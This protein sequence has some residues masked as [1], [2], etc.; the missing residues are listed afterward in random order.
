MKVPSRG[1]VIDVLVARDGAA[2]RLYFAPS[3]WKPGTLG[4]ADR[5]SMFPMA[6]PDFAA[7]DRLMRKAALPFERRFTADG[8]IEVRSNGR[9]AIAVAAWLSK[10]I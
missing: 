9:A 10:L 8:G 4:T 5:N 3:S 6:P 2:W 7:L 1:L